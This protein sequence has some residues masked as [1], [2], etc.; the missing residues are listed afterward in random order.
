MRNWISSTDFLSSIIYFEIEQWN[1]ENKR[2]TDSCVS[3]LR[4]MS[5]RAMKAAATR[6]MRWSDTINKVKLSS[7]SKPSPHCEVRLIRSLNAIY[8][9]FLFHLLAQPPPHCDVSD[10]RSKYSIPINVMKKKK[11]SHYFPSSHSPRHTRRVHSSTL[12]SSLFP[13]SGPVSICNWHQC[14]IV[15]HIQT[16]IGTPRRS[17]WALRMRWARARAREWNHSFEFDFASLALKS[18]EEQ[19]WSLL[20][21]F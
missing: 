7:T 3:T 19:I 21:I 20:T 8:L 9:L 14:T 12:I 4:A 6:T 18:F 1:G 16:L 17:L 11:V 13:I 2:N 5:I 15:Q 10:T